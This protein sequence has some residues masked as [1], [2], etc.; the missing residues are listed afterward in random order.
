[1]NNLKRLKKAELIEHIQKLEK[2]QEEYKAKLIRYI[3][4]LEKEKTEMNDAIIDLNDKIQDLVIKCKYAEFDA[5]AGQ[6]EIDYLKKLL[7]DK[8]KNK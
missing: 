1:M 4:D 8:D 3:K 2:D 6:R 5:E 7:K